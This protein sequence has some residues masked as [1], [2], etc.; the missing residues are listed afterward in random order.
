MDLPERLH[1]KSLDS[2]SFFH[3]KPI[4]GVVSEAVGSLCVRSS[5]DVDGCLNVCMGISNSQY[6]AEFHVA[7]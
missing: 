4:L 2:F 3:L 1:I 6:D 5:V 7:G